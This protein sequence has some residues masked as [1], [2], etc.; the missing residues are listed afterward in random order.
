MKKIALFLFA[1]LLLLSLC[2]CDAIPGF[3]NASAQQHAEPTDQTQTAVPTDAPA[4]EAQPTPEED[5]APDSIYEVYEFYDAITASLISRVNGISE[6]YNAKIEA[7]EDA[8]SQRVNLYYLPF[9]DMESID[10]VY[11]NE[12]TSLDT[13][14][15]ACE[16]SGYENVTVENTGTNEYT[17]CYD[18]RDPEETAEAE[19]APADEGEESAEP[20]GTVYNMKKVFKGVYG[21][22]PSF[23]FY[24][25]TNGELS[26]F[27]EYKALGGDR[28][29]LMDMSNRVLLSYKDGEVSEMLHAKNIYDYDWAAGRIGSKTV[30]NAY[31]EESIWERGDITEDWVTE[32]ESQGC[33][34]RL[35]K[36]S[37]NSLAVTGLNEDYNYDTGEKLFTPGYSLA[38]EG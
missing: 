10:A 24:C 6:A 11:F 12:G 8:A 27:L 1:A 25:Y 38:I 32:H 3:S 14:K 2:S 9:L 36:L 26:S 13:I 5:D 4:A 21:E 33:I 28:Y 37:G 31:P 19:E 30:L 22:E 17:I 15:K 7:G 23:A 20:L 16:K 34:Y 35:Y 18:K 29:A